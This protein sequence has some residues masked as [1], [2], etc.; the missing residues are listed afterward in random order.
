M[1]SMKSPLHSCRFFIFIYI[2][3]RVG[4]TQGILGCGV[5]PTTFNDPL[6]DL[7]DPIIR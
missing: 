3:Q 6:F 2:V 5:P 1:E 4:E 7:L